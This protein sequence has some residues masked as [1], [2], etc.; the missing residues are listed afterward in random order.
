MPASASA[1]SAE[2]PRVYASPK[3]PIPVDVPAG[4][5]ARFEAHRGDRKGSVRSRHPERD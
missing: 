4:I 3:M 5:L 2:L 1:P